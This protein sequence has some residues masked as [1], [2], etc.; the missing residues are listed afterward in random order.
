MD[1]KKLIINIIANFVSFAVNFA[2]SFFLTPYI[3]ENIGK[4]AYGFFTLG[5]NFT[6]YATLATTA[7]NSMASRFIA[8]NIHKGDNENANKYFTSVFYSNI[9]ISLILAIPL[10]L[11]IVF[12]TRL[13]NISSS[14][15]F[16]VQLLWGFVF[17]SFLLGICFNIFS[18][19]FFIKNSLY[20]SSLR[21]VE[22]QLI[23]CGFL[24]GAYYFL[25]PNIWY[26]GFSACITAVYALIYNIRYTNKM[27]PELKVNRKYFDI[28]KVIELISTG[29]WNTF[30]QLSE[31]LLAGMDVYICNIWLGESMMGILAITKVVPSYLGTIIGMISTA[32]EPQLMKTYSTDNTDSLVKQIKFCNKTVMIISCIPIAGFVILGDVFFKL[33]LPNEDAML[34]QLLSIT[35]I[36]S[37]FFSSS[38]KILYYIP[39]LVNKLKGTTF[40]LFI[41]GVVNVAGVIILLKFSNL[42]VYAIALVSCVVTS[43]RHVT[44][45]PLYISHCLK[46][47]WTAFYPDIFR[48][49]FCSAVVLT[50]GYLLRRVY[51]VDSWITL[52]IAATVT[53]ILSFTVNAF[54]ILTKQ[55]RQSLAV[56]VKQ[57]FIKSV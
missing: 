33:W 39:V 3:I 2:V 53:A 28:K 56:M 19:V 16:D 49:L 55:E 31:I 45:T 50:I 30:N 57:R 13:T 27:I 47:K 43:I 9:I 5:N 1:K 23:K 4:E 21:S 37:M 18:T 52:I 12:I 54:I 7:L 34:L 15:I 41:T 44:F 42:G 20:L 10:T 8:I 51:T 6:T 29:M 11:C 48:G 22:A 25:A 17:L 14:I 36:V 40:F 35:A 32:F 24:F 46:I 26:L 38:I